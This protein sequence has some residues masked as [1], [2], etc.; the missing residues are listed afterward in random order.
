MSRDDAVRAAVDACRHHAARGADEEHDGPWCVC[1][2]RWSAGQ[3]DD[4]WPELWEQHI[5]AVALDA[6]A[7]HLTADLVTALSNYMDK[8]WSRWEH[9]WWGDVRDAFFSAG[10]E[11]T[12]EHFTDPYQLGKKNADADLVRERD[13]ALAEV[14]RLRE[15]LRTVLD[16]HT[17][18]KP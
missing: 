11:F 16:G 3:D 17:G 4:E 5:H 18:R 10:G 2:V 1:G 8:P 13:E 14:E 6:A 15:S 9:D 7:P 12:P